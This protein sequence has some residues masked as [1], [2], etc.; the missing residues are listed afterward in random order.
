MCAYSC[1][2]QGQGAGS[3][4]ARAV[5]TQPDGGEDPAKDE[6]T[7]AL[8]GRDAAIMKGA[9]VLSCCQHHAEPKA[10]D[11]LALKG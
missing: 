3:L 5:G 8:E 11:L 1:H 2:L 4:G 7:A 6:A 10:R 9:L